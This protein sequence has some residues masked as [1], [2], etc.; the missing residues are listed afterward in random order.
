[1]LPA[2]AGDGSEWSLRVEPVENPAPNQTFTLTVP[3]EVEWRLLAL[4]LLYSTD[5]GLGT[6]Y[7]Y[8]RLREQ[9]R[10]LL[11]VPLGVGIAPSANVTIGWGDDVG[12]VLGDAAAGMVLAPWPNVPLMPGWRLDWLV[13]GIGA[14]DAPTAITCALLER[15]TG[16]HP[17]ERRPAP[18]LVTPVDVAATLAP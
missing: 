14:A 16:E 10:E 15:W 7:P 8:L 9:N 1:M 4:N 2:L 5:A 12:A 17:P 3:G 11:R 13:E 18:L 6:R